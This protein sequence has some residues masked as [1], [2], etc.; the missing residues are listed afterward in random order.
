[1]VQLIR[2]LVTVA[3][4]CAVSAAQAQAEQTPL[5]L[6]VIDCGYMV[7]I[8]T[9]RFMPHV[10]DRPQR[11]DMTNRCYLVDHPDGTLVW[12]LGF[13]KTP[14]YRMLGILFWMKSLGR[15]SVEVGEPL[16]E[17]LIAKGFQPSDIDFVAMSHSHFDHIGEANAFAASTWLVQEAEHDWV[18]D[19]SLDAENVDPDLLERLRN[20]DTVTINGQ[21]DVF[22]DGRVMILS[23]P[24]HTPGHQCLFI[25]LPETGPI[26]LS[27]DLYHMSMSRE[28][29]SVPDFNTDRDETLRSMDFIERFVD[30]RGAQLWIQ[31][32]PA[33]GPRAPAIVH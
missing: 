5:S 23:S 20:A 33:S 22:G 19:E 10:P 26:V 31:H 1:M 25:D 18:L 11:M 15:S 4:L 14:Y 21:H 24:G 27:G 7:G 17:Q 16:T 13:P 3:A 8:E 28:R 12:D 6:H 9:E 32:D 2:S 29:R 30:A